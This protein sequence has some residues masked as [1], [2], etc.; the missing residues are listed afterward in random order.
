MNKKLRSTEVIHGSAEVMHSSKWRAYML[1]NR[2]VPAFPVTCKTLYFK[3]VSLYVLSRA[4]FKDL[5]GHFRGDISVGLRVMMLTT[6]TPCHLRLTLLC[7]WCP[8]EVGAVFACWIEGCYCFPWALGY[9]TRDLPLRP[10]RLHRDSDII[11]IWRMGS[12]WHRDTAGLWG[13][14][15]SWERLMLTG[16]DLVVGRSTWRGGPRVG[17]AL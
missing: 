1:Q 11:S 12:S 6:Q 3:E 17:L 7:R 9:V 5:R 13:H 15:V 8:H 14:R 10:P 4:C 2:E 16:P